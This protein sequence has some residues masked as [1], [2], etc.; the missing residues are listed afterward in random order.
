METEIYDVND[1]IIKV[2]EILGDQ[3]ESY[4]EWPGLYPVT[5]RTVKPLENWKK[6]QVLRAF[7]QPV[8]VYFN[9]EPDATVVTKTTK[10][11]NAV[12]NPWQIKAKK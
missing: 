1:S 7:P 11:S 6:L 10:G 12:V 5:I 9:S 4:Q 3:L 2:K 8:R